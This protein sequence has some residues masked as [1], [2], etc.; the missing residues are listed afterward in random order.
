MSK[1][2]LLLKLK[3]LENLRNPNRGQG[4]ISLVILGITL[5]LFFFLIGSGAIA[6]LVSLGFSTLDKSMLYY[7]SYS[8]PFLLLYDLFFRVTLPNSNKQSMN[9]LFI[10]P[11]S[12]KKVVLFHQMFISTGPLIFIWFSL[13][14]SV[15]AAAAFLLGGY[16][17]M[18]YS[19][20]CFFLLLVLNKQLFLYTANHFKHRKVSSLLLFI[21]T[22]ALL[23]T[24]LFYSKIE[25]LTKVVQNLLFPSSLEVFCLVVVCYLLLF[26]LSIRAN[27]KVLSNLQADEN[28]KDNYQSIKLNK[29][30]LKRIGSL[31]KQLQVDIN[32]L[33]RTKIMRQVLY[34]FPLMLVV[35]ILQLFVDEKGGPNHFIF[36]IMPALIFQ[37]F[38]KCEAT[39]SEFYYT[40]KR[41]TINLMKSKYLISF[42]LNTLLFI[43]ISIVS[44]LSS[45]PII[46]IFVAFSFAPGLS[47]F[48]AMQLYVFNT[49]A[50]NPNV[51]RS[52]ADKFNGQYFLI[53]ILVFILPP[54]SSA[55]VEQLINNPTLNKLLIISFN[56]LFIISLPLWLDNTHK[57]MIKRKHKNLE[58]INQT[59]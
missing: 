16:T 38:I 7:I 22:Y 49:S 18:C 27:N 37:N 32:L 54:I 14:S 31:S 6:L 59:R 50:V 48:I 43:L 55:I 57:R 42:I 40:Q 2:K 39:Y 8:L 33:F 51:K 21:G 30:I 3:Q 56:G 5:L 45:V 15:I 41:G 35:A 10:L 1:F 44:L 20:I 23:L 58:I 12:K 46:D 36:S 11:I 24:P 28:S 29:S 34:T 13:F 19:L 25:W 26:T 47:S 9:A 4:K 53:I 17:M 52:N